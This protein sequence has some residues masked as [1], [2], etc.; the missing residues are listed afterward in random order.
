MDTVTIENLRN[1]EQSLTKN[2]IQEIIKKEDDFFM[3]QLKYATPKIKGILTK[4]KLKWRGIKLIEI[5]EI[6]LTTKWVEQRGKQLGEKLHI[7]YL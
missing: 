2:I 1:I 6:D 7:S 3:E 5:N 4:G